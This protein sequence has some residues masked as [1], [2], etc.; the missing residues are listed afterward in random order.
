MLSLYYTLTS[1]PI[2]LSS[3]TF[4]SFF[5]YKNRRCCYF[6]EHLEQHFPRFILLIC[7]F[8]GKVYNC[9]VCSLS[10]SSLFSLGLFFTP[11][12]LPRLL[13]INSSPSSSSF[14]TNSW[15][16]SLSLNLLILV[17]ISSI[18]LLSNRLAN[19]WN[20]PIYKNVASLAT[21]CCF[22]IFFAPLGRPL[23]LFSWNF[24]LESSTNSSSDD[25]SWLS[26][27]RFLLPLGLPRQRWS[28]E[29]LYPHKNTSVVEIQGTCYRTIPQSLPDL[30]SIWTQKWTYERNPSLTQI[31]NPP[32]CK[33][34]GKKPAHSQ[35]WQ[36]QSPS[37]R[38]N[39]GIDQT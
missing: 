15:F 33:K 8:L 18:D 26:F 34:W 7:F 5:P 21:N 35:V 37:D 13:L 16:S 12:G 2:L 4:I 30:V 14:F 11:L 24:L 38:M 25:F 6:Y 29:L 3:L 10:D 1:S 19:S 23:P 32:H 17:L 20:T 22:L 28:K 9:W 36:I 31:S 39:R 27:L